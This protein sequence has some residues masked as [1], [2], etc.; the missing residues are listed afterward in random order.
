M[1]ILIET[2]LISQISEKSQSLGNQGQ[3]SKSR[4]RE[5]KIAGFV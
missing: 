5:A 3:F 2:Y 1:V 4:C